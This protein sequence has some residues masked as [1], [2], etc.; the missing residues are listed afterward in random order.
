MNPVVGETVARSLSFSQAQFDRFA[1]LSGDDNPIHIDADF[2]ARTRFGR[3]VAHGMFLYATLRQSLGELAP[4]LR[5]QEQSLIFSAPTYAGEP[6]S[7]RLTLVAAET[8]GRVAVDSELVKADGRMSCQG[9]ALLHYDRPHH[10]AIGEVAVAA[11]STER[12]RGLVLGQSATLGRA[13]TVANVADYLAL[14][15]DANPLFNDDT[16]ASRVGLRG[17]PLPEPLLG[18]LFSCLLGTQLPGR[19]TNWLKQRL[20]FHAPVYPGDEL[21]GRVQIVRLRPEKELVSLRTW[22]QVAGQTICDGEALVWVGDKA[23]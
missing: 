23:D 8:G 17:A 15:A 6:L 20:V 1:A 11:V 21:Q 12:W 22:I 2:A 10:P 18:A 19:G 9:H 13:Y 14:L 3:P 7:L 16:F 4:G 5:Q